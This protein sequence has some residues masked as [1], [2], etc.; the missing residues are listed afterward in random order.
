MRK[1]NATFKGKQ[2]DN[3]SKSTPP[4]NFSCWCKN[5]KS[6]KKP[7]C[8][9]NPIYVI[10]IR[11]KYS[12]KRNCAATSSNFH[13]HVS[14]RYLHIPRIGPHTIISCSRIADGR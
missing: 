10:L 8:N 12:Q 14:V 13:I 11:N 2:I 6:K 7:H 5:L 3:V 9:E 4:P 1:N